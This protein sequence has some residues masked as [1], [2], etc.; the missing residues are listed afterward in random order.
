[1]KPVDYT[2][3]KPRE[4]KVVR[5]E[6]VKEQG[7]LCM[8]CHGPLDHTPIQ[9]KK[10]DWRLF[11]LGFLKNPVHLQHNHVTGLTEGAIHAYCNAV[12]WQYH[13]K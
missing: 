12:L 6:Y 1:M 2:K 10:I 7:G 4:R 5:E 8:F 9:D 3:L 13:G 11:P